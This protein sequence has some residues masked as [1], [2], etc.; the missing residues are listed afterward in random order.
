MRKQDF[1]KYVQEFG[2]SAAVHFYTSIQPKILIA[3]TSI[4]SEIQELEELKLIFRLIEYQRL[5]QA[6]CFRST[7][8]DLRCYR[9]FFYGMEEIMLTILFIFIDEV[10]PYACDSGA[11]VSLEEEELSF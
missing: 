10:R 3:N 4:K 9:R 6:G 2:L 1:C 11:K 8:R 7:F 5:G